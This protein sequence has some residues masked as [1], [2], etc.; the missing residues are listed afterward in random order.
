MTDMLQ[1][2]ASTNNSYISEGEY[3]SEIAWSLYHQLISHYLTSDEK[4]TTS[5]SI[6]IANP[7]LHRDVSALSEFTIQATARG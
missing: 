2:F 5:I 6:W 1:V 3:P 4:L 7:K